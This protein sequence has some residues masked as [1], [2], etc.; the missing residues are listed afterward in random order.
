MSRTM[1]KTLE[2]HLLKV[3]EAMIGEAVALAD[4]ILK[5]AERWEILYE[6]VYH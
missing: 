2:P 4:P 3:R 5:I 6:I 1:D